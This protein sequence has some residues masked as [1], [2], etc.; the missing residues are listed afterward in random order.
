MSKIQDTI[1]RFIVDVAIITSCACLAVTTCSVVKF[2]NR[3]TDMTLPR[4]DNII[5][6]FGDIAKRAKDEGVARAV[7]CERRVPKDS[8]PVSVM[9]SS[10]EDYDFMQEV[11]AGI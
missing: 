3:V 2:V 5:V 11:Y 7:F 6:H 1:H 4:V 8:D 9:P 10:K